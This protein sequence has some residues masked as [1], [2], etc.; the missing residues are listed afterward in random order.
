MLWRLIGWV[1]TRPR[2]TDWLIRRAQR[3]PFTHLKGYMNR[4]WLFN[5]RWHLSRWPLKSLPAIRIH[6]ILRR[7]LDP[8]LHD[9]PFDWR[10]IVLR[11][12]YI[13]EDVFGDL[14]PRYV[15]DTCFRRA[16]E[17]HNIIHVSPGGVWTLFICGRKVQRWGFLVGTPAR[18]VW[19]RRHNQERA[20]LTDEV[21]HAE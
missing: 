17:F 14:A 5:P 15:G 21:S 6:Q 9:H 12:S 7:D 1:V 18:K 10:T 8:A 3:R 19:H 16:T 13:E 20:P 4:W 11:G 2:I